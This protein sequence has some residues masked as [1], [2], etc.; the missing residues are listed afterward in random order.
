[1]VDTNVALKVYLE[2]DLAEEAQQVLDA[3]KVGSTDLLAPTLILPEFRHALAKRN[4]RG[5]L[6]PTETQEIWENF[7]YYPLSF[8]EIGPLVP[9]AAEIVDQA[10]CTVYDA[11]FVALAEAEGTV[12][13]TAERRLLNALKDTPFAAFLWPLSRIDEL[14]RGTT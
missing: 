11:I 14:L 3:G 4:R 12:M 5:E 8:F 10:G 6:S 7:G 1:V 13:V 9:R 2:E